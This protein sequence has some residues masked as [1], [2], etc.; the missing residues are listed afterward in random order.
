MRG[1]KSAVTPADERGIAFRPQKTERKNG[2]NL[3][4][5]YLK[6]KKQKNSSL[7][8]GKRSTI[9]VFPT[10]PEKNTTNRDFPRQSKPALP[11]E[12]RVLIFMG[13]RSRTNH[14]RRLPTPSIVSGCHP[15]FCPPL[16]ESSPEPESSRI[17]PP[18][19]RNRSQGSH[20]KAYSRDPPPLL[21]PD[22]SEP[23]ALAAGSPGHPGWY[24]PIP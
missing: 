18:A 16:S 6:R 7:P 15:R 11:V 5:H 12:R 24:R 14:R 8:I 2:T 10:P 3:T 9:I 13:S 22:I 1:S 17:G 21:S 20:R 4:Y 19:G 23:A